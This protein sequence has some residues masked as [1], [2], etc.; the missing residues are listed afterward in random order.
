LST[1]NKK[2]RQLGDRESVRRTIELD[3][4]HDE[5]AVRSNFCKVSTGVRRISD[6]GEP[7]D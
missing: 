6:E 3:T 5:L 1:I 4:K 7:V 2:R